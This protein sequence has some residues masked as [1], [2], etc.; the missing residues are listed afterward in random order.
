MSKFGLNLNQMSRSSQVLLVG[1]VV[2]LISGVLLVAY[3]QLRPVYQVLFSDLR[4]QDAAAIVAE[5]DKQKVPYRLERD[6]N[7][8]LV[9]E[10]DVLTTRLKVMSH[11]IPLK[12]A[13]GFELFNSSDLGLTEFSQKVN[14]QRALQGELARTIMS[15][16]EIE[17][18]RVHLALPESSI[19]RRSAAK[20]KAS[21]A[22]ATHTGNALTADTVK[23][24]Q[25]LVAAAVPD[26][27]AREVTV[28][29]QRGAPVS[30]GSRDDELA[31]DPHLALKASLERYYRRKILELIE[32]IVGTG[33]AAI[34]VDA[35]LNLDQ[36]RITQESDSAPAAPAAAVPEMLPL[37]PLPP[38]PGRRLKDGIKPLDAALDV[39]AGEMPVPA[40]TDERRNSHRVEQI[41]A[42]PG[43]IRRMNV[44]VVLYTSLNPTDLARV[45]EL[46]ATTVGLTPGRG[47]KLLMMV[48][49]RTPSQMMDEEVIE[50]AHASGEGLGLPAKP[51]VAKKE[52]RPFGNVV[53]ILAGLLVAA[54]TVLAVMLWRSRQEN[55]QLASAASLSDAQR[56]EYVRRLRAVL[57][58]EKTVGI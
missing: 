43:S 13:V 18:A 37:P 25:R 1:A 40:K 51:V 38:L 9:Q 33:N 26:L 55:L 4:S 44:G 42:T 3:W 12:G 30:G 17:S 39:G 34:S 19:F 46:I 11:D 31:D 45:N 50:P 21:V 28:L 20:P 49:A 52:V 23:G 5:L 16:G 15:L 58:E 56:Q 24:I 2:L 53:S 7:T 57:S 35:L 10:K 36:V 29:D 47:D 22:I 48:R 8:I 6:G 27:E 54:L 41:V 32:P 14:F